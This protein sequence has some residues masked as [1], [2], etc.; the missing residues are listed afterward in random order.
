[1]IYSM[2]LR[3]DEWA[4]NEDG[5]SG[6]SLRGALKG[7]SKH[8]VSCARLWRDAPMPNATNEEAS[9]WWLDAMKR[10]LGAY[11]RISP[12]CIRDIH[13][14][15]F[16]TGVVYASATAHS[17][18]DLLLGDEDTPA[19]TTKEELPV[20][21]Y[22]RGSPKQGHAFAIVG[23]TR[24]GFVIQN[25][26]GPEWGRGGFAVLRYDDWVVNAMDCW[27]VQLGV[28]TEDHAEVA[29]APSLRVDPAGRAVVSENPDL[30]DHEIAPFVIDMEN[31][32][33][34]SSTGRFRTT[35]D[36]LRALI[37]QHLQIASDRWGS[38][39][40]GYID[41]A[42]YA[43]GGLDDEG[44]AAE[45]ARQW[46]PYLYSR[47]IFPVF[48]MWET[49]AVKTLMDIFEDAVRGEAQKVAGGALNKLKQLAEDWYNARL[50]GLVRIPGSKLWGK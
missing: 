28:V 45:I 13:I 34:L 31:E 3:Y 5:Q 25:S 8:G 29:R 11:Y 16:E 38:V 37:E 18:W 32:G 41:V 22:K 30:A 33:R 20:I 49:G 24:T 44:R 39:Q 36:D 26:W 27:V 9:D 47:Q 35:N 40:S 48:L 10:P 15:L 6:S 2:A 50:E 17:N 21:S 42:L 19:P 7:W 14:A 12:E 43:H 23:Y 1:M 4:D 46:I